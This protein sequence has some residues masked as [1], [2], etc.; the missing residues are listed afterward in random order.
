MFQEGPLPDVPAVIL[1][2]VWFFLSSFISYV[3][4]YLDKRAARNGG[5]RIPESRLQLWFILGG[6]AGGKY[7]QRRFRHKTRKHPFA[8]RLN[9]CLVLNLVSYIGLCI[10]FVNAY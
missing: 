1:L 5:W 6:A 8:G 10:Y 9:A 2:V 3:M 4:M 7:A